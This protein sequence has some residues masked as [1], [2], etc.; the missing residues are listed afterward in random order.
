MYQITIMICISWQ[1]FPFAS[2]C[3]VI[4]CLHLFPI[5]TLHL[6][7]PNFIHRVGL[8]LSPHLPEEL[9]VRARLGNQGL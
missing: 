3:N 2:S 7:S 1:S 8:Q 6:S 5:V 4:P 9:P